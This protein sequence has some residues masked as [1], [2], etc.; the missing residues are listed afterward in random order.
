[1]ECENLKGCPI[2]TGRMKIDDA[3]ANMYKKNYC[4][5]DKYKCAR[6]MVKTKVGKSFVASDLLPDMIDRAEKIIKENIE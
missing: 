2:Y 3:L 6:Y 1:M 4:E 5:K